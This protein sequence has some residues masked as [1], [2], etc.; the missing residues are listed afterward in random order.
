M[1]VFFPNNFWGTA[2]W[3]LHSEDKVCV[4][5][6]NRTTILFQCLM[7]TFLKVIFLLSNHHWFNHWS[8]ADDYTKIRSCKLTWFTTCRKA[9]YCP[10]MTCHEKYKQGSA[11]TWQNLKGL[12]GNVIPGSTFLMMEYFSL[13]LYLVETLMTL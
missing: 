7:T 4:K 3:I 5:E 9:T 2:I 10:Q 8:G 12:K 13:F 1:P 11:P 6:K